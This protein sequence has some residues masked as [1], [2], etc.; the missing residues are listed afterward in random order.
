MMLHGFLFLT[1]FFSRQEPLFNITGIWQ[2][3]SESPATRGVKGQESLAIY[4]FVLAP[5]HQ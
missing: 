5:K 1:E 3:A 2:D 4:V